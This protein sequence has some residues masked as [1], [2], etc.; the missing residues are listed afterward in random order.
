MQANAALKR[1]LSVAVTG[2]VFVIVLACSSGGR[3]AVVAD[4]DKKEKAAAGDWPLYGGTLQRNF[5]NTR[6]RNIPEKWSAED[7][8]NVKWFADLGS[9]AYGGPV[10]A[11]GKV[12]IG[13]NNQN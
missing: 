5:V 2:A 8:T 13:T 3:N 6:E 4:D 1:W 9:K 11:G 10:V 12:F 7:G